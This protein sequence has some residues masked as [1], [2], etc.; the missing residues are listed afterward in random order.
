MEKQVAINH[1]RRAIDEALGCAGQ[2]GLPF[3][4]LLLDMARLE[5]DDATEDHSNIVPISKWVGKRR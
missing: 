3:V 2:A 1:L 4:V 5:V